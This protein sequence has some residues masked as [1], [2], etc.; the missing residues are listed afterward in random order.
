MLKKIIKDYF[1]LNVAIFNGDFDLKNCNSKALK[2]YI[3]ENSDSLS[4]FRKIGKRRDGKNF[5]NAVS[6]IEKT[7]NLLYKELSIYDN[8]GVPKIDEWHSVRNGNPIKFKPFPICTQ[9]MAKCLFNKNLFIYPITPTGDKMCRQNVLNYCIKEFNIDKSISKDLGIDNICFAYSTTHAYQIII[10]TIARPGDVILY[11]APNYGIFAANTEVINARVELVDIYENDD[12]FVNPDLLDKR[13]KKIN[14]ELKDE[15]KKKGGYIP[16]VVAFFNMNPHN[17]LGKVMGIKQKNLLNQI[18]RVCKENGVFIIDDLIYRDLSFDKNNKAL[19]F[20]YFKE[21]FD[22]TISLIGLSK[23]YGLAQLRAGAILAPIPI[24]RGVSE[25]ITNS[26]DAY[27]IIQSYALAG[28]FNAT[29]RRDKIANKY[30]DKLIDSY[31]YQY[32]L[33]RLLIYGFENVESVNKKSL[34]KLIRNQVKNKEDF[35]IVK[36]GIPQTEIRNGCEPESGFF[37]IVD[38]SL[39]KNK[40]SD[41]ITIIN[42]LEFVKYIYKETKINF[43]IGSSFNWPNLE[44]IVARINFAILKEDLIYNMLLINKAVRKLR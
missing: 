42:D 26:V 15:Y 43:L 28:A 20:V 24:C 34:I 44:E 29:K 35:N 25:K 6:E 38:F 17:P 32:D 37:A 21:Y 33:L 13:I 31:K 9:F 7:Y 16:K 40:K 19:P 39:L 10:D 12:W 30:F 27:S 4:S 41:E 14:E 1:G 36:E 2:Q 5:Y 22:N 18:G 8:N 23:S 3:C 11:T